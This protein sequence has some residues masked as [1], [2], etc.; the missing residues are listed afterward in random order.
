MDIAIGAA[1]RVWVLEGEPCPFRLQ[2]LKKKGKGD[3]PR[4][5]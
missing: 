1:L 3:F 5:Q 2:R 4:V